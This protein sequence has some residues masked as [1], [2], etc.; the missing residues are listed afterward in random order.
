[1][2]ESRK[3]GEQ[4]RMLHYMCTTCAMMPLQVMHIRGAL[5]PAL[6]RQ[7]LAWLQ[8]QHPLLR[9]HIRYG[10]LVFRRLPPFI[11]RQPYFDTEGTTE[12]PFSVVDGE[13]QDVLAEELRKPMRRGRSP[14]LRVTLVRDAQDAEL[15]HLIFTA[16][17]ATLDAQTAH[18]L[19]RQLLEYFAEP[20]AMEARAPTHTHLPPPLEAGMPTKPDSGT[21][22]YVPAARLPSQRVPG[23]KRVTRVFS[24]RLDAAATDALKAAVKAN[25][26]T[27]HGAITGAFMLAMHQRYGVDEMSCL[28]SVDLRRLCKPPLPVETYGCYIDAL[29]T[30]HVLG[31]EL[32]PIARDVSFKLISTLAKDQGMASFLKLPGWEVYAAEVWPTIT[33][34]RRLDGLGVTTAG[35]SGLKATYGNHTLEGVTMAI[36]VDFVGPSLLVLG[37]ERLG[38]LDLSL[39]YAAD[40]LPAAD[41]TAL[42]DLG[43]AALAAAGTH[44]LRPDASTPV[45]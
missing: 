33:H 14:R 20:A 24:R 6:I 42:A 35:D 36:S 17:H 45:Q 5:D 8:R 27:M 25:R 3:L 34:H 16:D 39:C 11:Y 37:A 13:W 44:L 43:L 23:G 41:A 4:E 26:T 1:M 21:R 7:A 15:N 22:H 38:G 19:S 18:L 12:I 9:A 10:G 2:S 29:R 31:P 32:W 40:A 30:R 28:S